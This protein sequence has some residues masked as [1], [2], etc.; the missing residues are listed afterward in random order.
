MGNI[1]TTAHEAITL[2]P[3]LPKPVPT[4]TMPT[5]YVAVI[6]ACTNGFDLLHDVNAH[7]A[8]TM[9]ACTAACTTAG[10]KCVSASWWLSGR[11]TFRGIKSQ[12]WLSTSCVSP[13]CC[14]HGHQTRIKRSRVSPEVLNSTSM[15]VGD[16]DDS[17]VAG[18]GIRCPPPIDKHKPVELIKRAWARQHAPRFCANGSYIINI[19]AAWQGASSVDR[20]G[21]QVKVVGQDFAWNTMEWARAHRPACI[22]PTMIAWEANSRKLEGLYA[23]RRKYFGEGG[24]LKVVLRGGLATPDSISNSIE[25]AH[26]PRRPHLLKVDIDSTDLPVVA[27]CL[28]RFRPYVLV[29]EVNNFTP[30]GID[31]VALVPDAKAD[32]SLRPN[33]GSNYTG[34]NGKWPCW[35]SS[36]GY[37]VRWL[38][39][40]HGYRLLTTDRDNNAIFVPSEDIDKPTGGASDWQ[41]SS[42]PWCHGGMTVADLFRLRVCRHTGKCELRRFLRFPERAPS[43]GLVTMSTTHLTDLL[44]PAVRTIYKNC[45]ASDVPFSLWLNGVCCPGAHA[46]ER[47]NGSLC[48][49]DRAAEYSV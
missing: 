5:D 12:C 19:G 32:A 17:S 24:G 46:H 47:G 15:L 23:V 49:C 37:W 11:T 13:N 9:A 8:T 35:G 7:A 48:R 1:P 28:K 44:T 45:D 30:L 29:V 20:Q 33:Y 42:S 39:R 16:D 6:G 3:T 41:W 27:A 36:L 43:A 2:P 18:L 40:R 21:Q 25:L 22:G 10:A 14:W 4:P 26:V 38:E 34:Y 31:F